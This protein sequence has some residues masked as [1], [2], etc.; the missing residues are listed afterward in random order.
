[1]PFQWSPATTPP[2]CSQQQP[3]YL[4]TL[5]PT[6][7]RK[8]LSKCWAGSKL[9]HTWALTTQL[10]KPIT[11]QGHWLVSLVYPESGLSWEVH[12]HDIH[13]NT[14]SLRCLHQNWNFLMFAGE[15][16]LTDG[17]IDGHKKRPMDTET[18]WSHC[19]WKPDWCEIAHMTTPKHIL[20]TEV[21]RLLL[22]IMS[23]SK[24]QVSH[25]S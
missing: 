10:H 3:Y 8:V 2:P 5:L 1:M 13:M 19:L 20:V 9:K 11:V 23:W 7:R 17:K 4:V 18:V 12:C 15:E 24:I 14:S 21:V 16:R 22:H 25:L 6:S